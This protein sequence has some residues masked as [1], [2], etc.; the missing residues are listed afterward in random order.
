MPDLDS[1]EDPNW[2]LETGP[3]DLPIMTD[4]KTGE[5]LSRGGGGGEGKLQRLAS[6]SPS[7]S[8]QGEQAAAQACPNLLFQ[9]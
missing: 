2:A 4:I 5:S 7:K 8:E 1:S 3:R 9:S 6:K